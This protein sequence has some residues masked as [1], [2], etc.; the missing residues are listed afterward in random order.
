[1]WTKQVRFRPGEIEPGQPILAV[2]NDHLSI[3]NGRDVGAG[4]GCEQRERLPFPVGH[5]SPEAG[6]AEPVLGRLGKFPLR[7]RRF[8]S[9]ELEEVRGG[10]EAPP[11]REASPFGAEIDDRRSL[12]PCRRKPP[13]QLGGSK[14]EA[15][16]EICNSP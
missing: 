9:G 4:I 8:R 15:R 2:E 1:M 3:V 13:T 11:F 14:T 6:E 5:R 7:F 10:N 12:R 16:A